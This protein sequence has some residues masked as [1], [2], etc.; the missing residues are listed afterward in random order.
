MFATLMAVGLLQNIHLR[1]AAG[2]GVAPS[3]LV[4]SR[5]RARSARKSA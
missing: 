5:Y 2:I 1:S 3:R 4:R